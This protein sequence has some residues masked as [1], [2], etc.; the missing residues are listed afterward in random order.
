MKVIALSALGL[1]I[2]A[3]TS[4]AIA[5]PIKNNDALPILSMAQP[6]ELSDAEMDRITA[7]TADNANCLPC[8]P[9]QVLSS[10]KTPLPPVLP[11]PVAYVPLTGP[12]LT[13][14]LILKQ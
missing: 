14:G 1:G 11:P 6:V 10:V 12:L 5:E 7:G 2:V 9:I 4:L 13:P 8:L 3:M